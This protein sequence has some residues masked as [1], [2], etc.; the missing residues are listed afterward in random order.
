MRAR[1]VWSIAAA[2]AL[3]NGSVR[4]DAPVPGSDYLLDVRY[5]LESVDDAGFT[6]SALAQTMRVRL[7]Y[8]WQLTP[9]WSAVLEGAYVRALEHRYNSTANG[10]TG[11]PVV[12]DPATTQINRAFI[13]YRSG[14]FGATLGRQRIELDNQR[15]IGASG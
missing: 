13:A 7:G 15:F 1:L 12:A 5:R 14:P 3:W 6:H 2:M 10:Q 11:Y 4:A 8:R 9:A